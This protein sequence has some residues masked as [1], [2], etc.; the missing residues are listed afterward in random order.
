MGFECWKEV[1]DAGG[2][3]ALIVPIMLVVIVS[4]VKDLYEDIKR[5]RF[6][7][8]ENNRKTLVG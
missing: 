8:M 3:P 2:Y 4:M 1:S 7:R 5:H 6:D